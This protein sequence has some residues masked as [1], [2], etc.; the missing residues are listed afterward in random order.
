MANL[1]IT[2]GDVL[3]S[4]SGQK[5]NGIAG[6]TITQ[7][8]LIYLKIADG[9]WYLMD[10][11]LDVVAAGAEITEVA[12]ALNGASDGQPIDY[13]Q[14]DDDFTPGATLA[15]G[16]VYLASATAGAIAPFSDIGGGQY[17]TFVGVATS[18]S[19]MNLRPTVGGLQ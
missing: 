4:S 11:D 17:G 18:T 8:E 2:D 1:I 3:A 16:E 12:V 9:E 7:G 13:V 15:V 5:R 14:V 10:A 19:K 6:E